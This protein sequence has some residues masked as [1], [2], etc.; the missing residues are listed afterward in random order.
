MEYDVTLEFE[1]T[2]HEQV[3][4]ANIGDRSPADIAL[5]HLQVALDE[6]DVE[7]TWEDYSVETV[8][9]GDPEDDE[10]TVEFDAEGTWRA[11][12]ESDDAEGAGGEA[13]RLLEAALNPDGNPWHD[14][15]AEVVDVEEA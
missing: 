11:T 14:F 12:V 4:P 5:D 13:T 2:W 6:G 15:D 1:G 7:G 10:T 3:S 8:D 9:G